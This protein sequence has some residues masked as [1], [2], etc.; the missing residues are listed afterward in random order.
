MGGE[1]VNIH[2]ETSWGAYFN[3]DFSGGGSLTNII[4]WDEVVTWPEYLDAS[5][6][7]TATGAPCSIIP[8]NFNLF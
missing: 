2:G 1:T 7:P 4:L 3:Y 5:S 8:K 6:T